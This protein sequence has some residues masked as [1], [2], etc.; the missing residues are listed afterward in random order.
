M[1]FVWF[2]NGYKNG[3]SNLFYKVLYKNKNK[4]SLFVIF[5]FLI[6]IARYWKRKIINIYLLLTFRKDISENTKGYFNEM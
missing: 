2:D 6:L 1:C 3:G 5:N 4:F